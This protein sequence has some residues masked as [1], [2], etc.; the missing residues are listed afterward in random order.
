MNSRHSAEQ[1]S[2]SARQSAARSGTP[3]SHSKIDARTLSA[4]ERLR[5][6]QTAFKLRIE[7]GLKIIDIAPRL[8]VHLR[9]VESWFQKLRT[10]GNA[11]LREKQRG[12]PLGSCRKLSPEQEQ[13]IRDQLRGPAP[14]GNRL[15]QTRQVQQLIAAQFALDLSPRLVRIYL[16]RWNYPFQQPSPLR[17]HRPT[18][19]KQAVRAC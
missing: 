7:E 12:R 2:P 11:G 1:P 17:N 13:S 19:G 16:R 8:G 6:R 15:W 10:Q 5:L 9:T 3:A 4:G 14:D 18:S